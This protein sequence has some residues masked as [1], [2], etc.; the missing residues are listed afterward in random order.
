MF[1][2]ISIFLTD[3]LKNRNLVSVPFAKSR[4]YFSDFANYLAVCL[5]FFSSTVSF[6]FIILPATFFI[7][8]IIQ[9]SS[10]A[11]WNVLFILLQLASSFTFINPSTNTFSCKTLFLFLQTFYYILFSSLA[12]TSFFFYLYFSSKSLSWHYQDGN[13]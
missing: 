3:F 10:V 8:H 9:H 13:K 6:P 1:Y 11:F 12:F 5:T 2:Y 4:P 7:L